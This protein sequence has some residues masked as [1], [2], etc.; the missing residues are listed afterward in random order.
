MAELN[1]GL[2]SYVSADQ[3]QIDTVISREDHETYHASL[4]DWNKSSENVSATNNP[5]SYIYEPVYKEIN[6]DR[7]EVVGQLIA[8]LA[9]D[10]YMV[11]LLPDGVNNITVV[12]KNTCNQSYTYD[13]R[14][15]SVSHVWLAMIP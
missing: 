7:S 12:L 3:F 6:N 2:F 5:H 13:V 11:D 4:V 15:N 14:G 10:K 8:Y 9:W 1:H